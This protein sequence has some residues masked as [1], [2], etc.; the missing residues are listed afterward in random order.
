MLSSIPAI[1]NHVALK[2]I[3]EKIISGDLT[4]FEAAEALLSSLHLVAADLESLKLVEV[5]A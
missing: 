3:K 5:S 4:S 2:F 1:G